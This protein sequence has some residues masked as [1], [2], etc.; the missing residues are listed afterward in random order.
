MWR[1]YPWL[2]FI[3]AIHLLY[4]SITISLLACDR[5]P[6]LFV[7]CSLFSIAYLLQFQASIPLQYIGAAGGWGDNTRRCQGWRGILLSDLEADF[8]VRETRVNKGKA[9]N[10]SRERIAG[11]CKSSIRVMF[12]FPIYEACLCYLYIAPV[13]LR[14]VYPAY[15]HTQLNETINYSYFFQ[16]F[17]SSYWWQKCQK[18]VKCFS[19]FSLCEK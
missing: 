3:R 16:V 15:V 9:S 5:N 11:F 13:F 17:I 12:M 14:S 6:V 1:F 18:D 2:F 19:F 8:Y 4:Y 7:R 10:I